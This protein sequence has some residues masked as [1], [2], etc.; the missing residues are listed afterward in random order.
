MSLSH[1]LCAAIAEGD[2]ASMELSLNG[3][4]IP[5]DRDLHDALFHAGWRGR[6]DAA[7]IL[8]AHGAQIEHNLVPAVIT[9][10][11]VDVLQLFLDRGYDLNSSLAVLR[12]VKI[13]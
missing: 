5:A 10:K 9:Y 12:C 11:S 7:S 1:V 4:T 3:D 6:A 2:I 13:I 8:L